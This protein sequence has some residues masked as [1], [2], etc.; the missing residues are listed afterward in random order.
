MSE[1]CI[2]ACLVSVSS[3]VLDFLFPLFW[4]KKV[5]FVEEAA[6]IR[7]VEMGVCSFLDM[8]DDEGSVPCEEASSRVAP[9]VIAS[10]LGE[11]DDPGHEVS[12]WRL[13]SSTATC[14]LHIGHSTCKTISS[15]S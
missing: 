1:G 6:G 9:L 11:E 5:D 7:G 13:I 4:L 10:L 12:R 2:R 15:V 8:D 3:G 14:L